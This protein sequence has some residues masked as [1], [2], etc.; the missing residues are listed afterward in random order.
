LQEIGK[1]P[2]F[3]GEVD[4]NR[5]TLTF[6]AMRLIVLLFCFL[7][8]VPLA[9]AKGDRLNYIIFHIDDLGWRDLGCYGSRDYETP[10]IDKMAG[11][12]MRFTNAYAACAVCSP[13]RAALLTG[14]H[15]YRIGITDWIRSKFQGGRI[16][17]DK[18]APSKWVGGKNREVSCPP[19]PLWME[20]EEVTLAEMLKEAGYKTC[21]IGKWHLGAEEWYPETQGFDLNHGG[22][23][24]GQPPSYFD[25]YVKNRQ[26]DIPT[27]P[28]K[29]TGEYLTDREA[30]EADDFI[31]EY[32]D[33][34]FFLH[35]AHYAVHTPIQAKEKLTKKY[36]KKKVKQGKPE[37]AAMIE[38]VD[39]S[40]GKVYEELKQNKIHRK[41]V[42]IFTSDNGGL[43]AN[44]ITSN[45]P[46]RSGKGYPY[47]GGIRVPSIVYWPGV[48]ERKT[49]SNYPITSVDYFATICAAEELPLPKGLE[50]DGI[51]LLP[52]LGRRRPSLDRDTL[53]WHF[54]H[55]RGGVVPYSIV[56]NHSDKLI[57]RYASEKR[58]EL[59][60]LKSDPSE[61]RDVAEENPR[62][63]RKLAAVL[64]AELKRT[65]A[66]VP[67]PNPAYSSTN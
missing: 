55:Y 23:D 59:F 34:P 28:P 39:D 35:M 31:E 5:A 6:P 40:V 22:C 51:N 12:G 43:I 16:P 1:D 26:G 13:T 20:H 45:A 65:G 42:I 63:V 11:R 19:N 25:P 7:S 52:I 47:E 67:Q 46:L 41:T 49:E 30:A 32:K 60:D 14:R 17:A 33:E 57:V 9:F 62:L 10:N 58:Y 8:L 53:F 18:S 64:D 66:K 56:R 3:Q 27:L 44:G 50:I 2:I 4:T 37:Y 36:A 15:P 24:Y 38:S 54:P 61:R 29:K 21:H 48:T